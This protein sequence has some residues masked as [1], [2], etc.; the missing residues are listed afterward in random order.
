MAQWQRICLPVQ[1]TGTQPLG[2]KD[3]LEKGMATYFSVL[4]WEIPWT[5]EPTVHGITQKQ[6]DMTEQLKKK[7]I[8]SFILY[9]LY[10]KEYIIC[11]CLIQVSKMKRKKYLLLLLSCS[12]MSNSLQPHGPQ[13]AR[14]P[15]PSPSSGACSNT[16]PLN[17]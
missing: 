13:Q 17:Q 15:C 1:E 9:M 4:T 10:Y 6:S 3:P 8:S 14:L 12:V 11:L 5:E 7:K 2:L 16:C